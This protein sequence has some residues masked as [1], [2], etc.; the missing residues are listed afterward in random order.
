MLVQLGI[1]DKHENL[2]LLRSKLPTTFGE[3]AIAEAARAQ[4]GFIAGMEGGGGGD[5]PSLLADADAAT[6]RDLTSLVSIA[7]DS[8]DTVEVDDAVSAEARMERAGT[9]A[10]EWRVKR[11]GGADK[12]TTSDD[13]DAAS[14]SALDDGRT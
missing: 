13:D 10:R 1:W 8:W 5:D 4:A 6:R 3:D 14:A 7:I 9:R 2:A 12:K 11:M